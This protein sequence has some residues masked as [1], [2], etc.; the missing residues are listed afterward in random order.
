MHTSWLTAKSYG[1]LSNQVQGAFIAPLPAF[2]IVRVSGADNRKYLQSQ[3]TCDIDQL[4]DTHFLRGAHCD[5]KGKTWS[6]FHL[7]QQGDELLAIAFRD[8]LNASVNQWRKFGVFSKVNFTAGH[9]DYAV[10]GIGGDEAHTL[11][12]QLGFKLPGGNGRLSR[13]EGGMVL[14]LAEQHYMLV[15]PKNNAIALLEQAYPLAAPTLW[16]KQHILQGL[17]YLEQPLIGEF[18]PQMLNLQA[19]SAIS[20]TKGCY[21][22]QETVARMKYLGRNK[23]A[24][25]ILQAQT[26]EAPAAG[27]DIEQQ[28]NDNWRRVG[29]VINAVNI[30]NQLWL[31]AVLPNDITPADSLRLKSDSAPALQL[32]PLPYPLS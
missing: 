15:L 31:I 14:Q 2:D 10:L 5:A 22:G 8:E 19:V 13:H 27:C 23:R 30:N 12:N 18:V 29:Q 26:D 6:V 11:V 32:L 4:D 21:L 25:W 3:T 28:F 1:Q 16:L 17:C 24:A 7:L 9:D 20:F